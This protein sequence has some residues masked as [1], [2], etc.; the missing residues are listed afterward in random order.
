LLLAGG[1]II[2]AIGAAAWYEKIQQPGAHVLVRVVDGSAAVFVV[3][4]IIGLITSALV[5]N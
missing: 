2:L 1:G 4:I 5:E 3:S